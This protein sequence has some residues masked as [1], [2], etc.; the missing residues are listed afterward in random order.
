MLISTVLSANGEAA[1]N[2]EHTIINAS[3]VSMTFDARS[4]DVVVID[5]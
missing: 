4:K 5:A 2:I 3:Q 1:E